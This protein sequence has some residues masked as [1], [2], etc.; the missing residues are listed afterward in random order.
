MSYLFMSKSLTYA[1][2][3]QR[4]LER[5]GIYVG[6][7]KAP[8]GLSAGGCSYSLSVPESKA[9]KAAGILRKEGLLTGKIYI[10]NDDG[11]TRE[12]VL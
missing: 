8:I 2:R 5:S 7:M 10:Q 11:S 6:I 9:A 3:S 1:Q 12:A 4:V